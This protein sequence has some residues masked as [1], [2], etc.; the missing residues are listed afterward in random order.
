ME[1][2]LIAFSKHRFGGNWQALHAVKFIFWM[3]SLLLVLGLG[4]GCHKAETNTPNPTATA[5][6]PKVHVAM[7]GGG[8]RAHTA[9]AGWTISLLKNGGRN[10]QDAFANVSTISS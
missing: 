6:P 7:S 8:W 10:L 2:I 1:N 4:N 3:C 5:P 9:H